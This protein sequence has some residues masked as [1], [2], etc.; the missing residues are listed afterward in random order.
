LIDWRNVLLI[1]VAAS[2]IMLLDVMSPVRYVDCRVDLVT[3][4]SSCICGYVDWR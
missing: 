4:W 3:S 1:S 2:M